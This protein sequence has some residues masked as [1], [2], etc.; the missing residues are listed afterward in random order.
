MAKIKNKPPD[1]GISKLTSP[2]F[3]SQVLAE[4]ARYDRRGYTQHRIVEAI[5]PLVKLSQ[6]TV[7]VLLKEVRLEYRNR[8]VEDRAEKVNEILQ[9]IRDVR[10]EAWD[11]YEKSRLN[12][13]TRRR[14]NVR[15]FEPKK[16]AKNSKNSTGKK[17]ESVEQTLVLLKEVV[18]TEGRLPANVYL[19]TVLETLKA[20]RELLGL[21]APKQLDIKQE[22]TLSVWDQ[23]AGWEATSLTV[24]DANDPIE[25]KILAAGVPTKE[26]SDDPERQV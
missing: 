25:A 13:V 17:G 4:I 6:P 16:G 10:S 8:A 24:V 14:E 3:K 22:T 23:L 9:S 19:Q 20:E 2:T 12:G 11:A 5:R 21:D 1:H 7:C 26:G 18:T 15:P